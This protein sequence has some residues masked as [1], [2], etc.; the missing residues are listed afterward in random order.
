MSAFG[1]ERLLG[2]MS[3]FAL[4]CATSF[5]FADPQPTP[6]LTASDVGAEM[7][8]LASF[9]PEFTRGSVGG[10][11]SPLWGRIKVGGRATLR[12]KGA[13]TPATMVRATPHPRPPP[14]EGAGALAPSVP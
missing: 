8:M 1:R 11:S 9:A 14:Q 12:N 7:Q 6:G 2:G 4:A 10:V 3:A 13:A 5:A